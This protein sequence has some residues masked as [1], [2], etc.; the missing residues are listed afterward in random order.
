MEIL[1]DK[2]SIRVE[3]MNQLLSLYKQGFDA[4]GIIDFWTN[5]Q[6]SKSPSKAPSKLSTVAMRC[7]PQ[8]K[9]QANLVRCLV[10]NSPQSIK[11]L[12]ISV[13]SNNFL[14]N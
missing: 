1:I 12:L 5:Q 9:H 3:M 7:E 14:Q 8:S 4:L 11:A 10:Q 6:L 13:N 2:K